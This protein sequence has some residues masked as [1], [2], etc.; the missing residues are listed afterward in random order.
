[1]YLDHDVKPDAN[2]LEQVVETPQGN[3]HRVLERDGRKL[4]AAEED[5]E[6]ARI[7]ENVADVSGRARDRRA[8]AQDAA[9]ETALLKMW[10]TAFYWSTASETPEFI[11][12][13]FRPDPHF[14]PPTIEARVMGQMT[15]QMVVTR[16]G[17]RLYSL[18]GRLTQDIRIAFGLVKLKA[19]GTFDVERRQIAPGHWQI[20]ESHTH[21]EGHALLLKS[22]GEQE[23]ETKSEFKPSPAQT[24]EQAAQ[25]LGASR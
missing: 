23:D 17:T 25:I 4:S 13:N 21:I 2:V 12:L 10:P 3:E 24:V 20:V 14:N 18:R 16:Q 11:T 6:S 1:M 9:K 22:I 5:A 8:G 15:G 7:R 19:G